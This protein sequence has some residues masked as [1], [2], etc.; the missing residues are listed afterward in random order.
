MDD[1][2]LTEAYRVMVAGQEKFTRRM[3]I[4]LANFAGMEPMRL[5][6]RLEKMG[7]ARNGSYDWFKSN[8]GITKD[9]IKEALTQ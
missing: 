4:H 2:A 8:G 9:H 5:V 7:L 1:E 6:W 3:A